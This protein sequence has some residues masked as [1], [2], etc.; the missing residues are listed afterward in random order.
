MHGDLKTS[1]RVKYAVE[2]FGHDRWFTVADIAD[3]AGLPYYAARHH[4]LR[5]ESFGD[6][7]RDRG[8]RRPTRWG[9]T[10]KAAAA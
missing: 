3:A 7:A 2:S 4:I 5:M 6:I 10:R 1:A 8:R 9:R